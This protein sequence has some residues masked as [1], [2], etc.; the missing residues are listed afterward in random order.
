FGGSARIVEE[1]LGVSG[2]D[3]LYV[4]D[5]IW[6]DVNVTKQTLR[7][8][9]ALIVQEIEEEIVS[10]GRASDETSA[11]EAGMQK[12]AVLE[13]RHAQLRLALTRL[14]AGYGPPLVMS[15]ADLTAELSRLKAD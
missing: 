13:R 4:G 12:K 15:E 5:H 6:G 11:L 14:R 10:A 1:S 7:W 3:I 2:D 8:R 9:T